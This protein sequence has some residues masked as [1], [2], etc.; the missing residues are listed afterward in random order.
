MTLNYKE[1]GK[2]LREA[3]GTRSQRE[4]GATLAISQAVLSKME[5]GLREPTA[6]ELQRFAHYYQRPLSFFFLHSSPNVSRTY[7]VRVTDSLLQQ[8]TNKIVET[9]HPQRIILFGSHVWGRPHRDSDIDLFVEMDALGT[10]RPAVRRFLVK[11]VCQPALV[12]LEI[13]VKTPTEMTERLAMGDLFMKQ[14]VEQGRILYD[15]TSN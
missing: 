2:R 14:I 1:L 13:Q 10:L 3:R 12:P 7:P 5:H 6:S 9:F 15:A 4:V 11:T 8:I